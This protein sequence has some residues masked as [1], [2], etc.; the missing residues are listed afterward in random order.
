[1]LDHV[2]INDKI[3]FKYQRVNTR[4]TFVVKPQDCLEKLYLDLVKY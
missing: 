2:F 1:M 3:V 4:Y